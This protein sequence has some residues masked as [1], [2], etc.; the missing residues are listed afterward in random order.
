MSPLGS[1]QPETTDRLDKLKGRNLLEQAVCLDAEAARLIW[2]DTASPRHL[3]GY[4]DISLLFSD[5]YPTY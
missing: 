3:Q 4:C 1:R 2:L 5:V